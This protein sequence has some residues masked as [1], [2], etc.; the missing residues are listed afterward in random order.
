MKSVEEI[1]KEAFES[2]LKNISPSPISFNLI[3]DNKTLEYIIRPEEFIS[4]LK[5]KYTGSKPYFDKLNSHLNGL[6][7]IVAAFASTP[8]A[9]TDAWNMKSEELSVTDVLALTRS[10]GHF[11]FNQLP[12]TGSM[13]YRTSYP[14]GLVWS[15]G[16]GIVK[17]FR[18]RTGGIYKDDDLNEMGIFTYA[19][20]TDAAG[21]MEYR[22]VEQFSKAFGIPTVFIITQWFKYNTPHEDDNNWLYMTAAAKVVSLKAESN[23]PIALQLISKDEALKHINNLSEAIQTK[24][25]YKVRPPM[26]EHIRLGWSYDKIKGDKR[27]RLLSYARDNRL[28]CPSAKCGH[29]SFLSLP[30]KEINVGHRISQNWN[31]QNFGVADVHHPYNLYLTCR[32]C[33][34]SLSDKYPTELDEAINDMGTIGD[35]LMSGSLI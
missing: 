10:G 17:G 3:K 14:K 28:A 20:P 2:T 15:K 16:T 23:S 34:I 5:A 6:R 13:L 9:F 19:T 12:G 8:T 21:M 29:S 35:W 7:H 11:Q 18:H 1:Y 31:V 27:K 25:L 26:P 30:D 33:N 32:A 24:G 22:F 4:A